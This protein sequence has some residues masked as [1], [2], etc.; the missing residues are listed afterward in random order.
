MYERKIT[1]HLDCSLIITM[2]IIGAKWKPCIIDALSRG[3]KRPSELHKELYPATPRV[4]DMQLSELK[5]YGI[6]AGKN[7]QGFP[8]R[9]DYELT[10]LGKSILPVISSMI[11]WG[12]ANM[13]TVKEKALRLKNQ[14][15]KKDAA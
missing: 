8:L 2:K 7:Q 13:S 14:S 11:E 3:I 15:A 1:E 12:E 10:D 5:D 6:I 9:T 4:I